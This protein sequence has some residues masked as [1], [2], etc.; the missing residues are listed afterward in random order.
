MNQ[1]MTAAILRSLLTN[2]SVLPCSPIRIEVDGA[3]AELVSVRMT[4]RLTEPD[5]N[6]ERKTAEVPAVVLD[7]RTAK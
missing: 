4:C 3:L 7:I 2:G 6:G 1:T 5:C